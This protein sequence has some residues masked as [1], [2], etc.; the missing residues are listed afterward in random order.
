MSIVALVCVLVG[1][2]LMGALVVW[3]MRVLRATDSDRAVASIY[4]FPSEP[5]ALR[6]ATSAPGPHKLWIRFAVEHVGGRYDYGFTAQVQ[7]QVGSAPASSVEMRVGAMA[8]ALGPNGVHSTNLTR[9]HYTMGE[10]AATVEI[11]S[12]PASPP[13]TPVAITGKVVVAQ[14]S[15]ATTLFVF[16]MPP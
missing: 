12:L 11:A 15:A 2:L 13:G 9:A 6:F 14:G 8:P 10:I 16:V 4:A 1:V 5:F 7:L 3:I